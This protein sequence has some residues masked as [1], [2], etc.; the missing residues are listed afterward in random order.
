MRS[1]I[2]SK[3]EVA[4]EGTQLKLSLDTNEDGQ[5]LM[6]LNLNMSEA[7]AEAFKK[8]VAIEG[9]KLVDF[10]FL[11]TKLVLALDTDK[12]GEKVLELE[13]DLMEALDETGVMKS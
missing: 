5:K 2:V 13:I 7:V 3:F 6:S 1:L 10:K 4:V 11:G 8:G 9:A 12:D